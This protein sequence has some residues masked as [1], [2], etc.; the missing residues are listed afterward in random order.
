VPDTPSPSL[1]LTLDVLR[2]AAE[3]TRLRIL[4]LLTEGELSVSDLTDILGQS[5]PRIS[6]HLKLLVEAGLVERHREGAWA[7]FRLTD[8]GVALSIIRPTIESLDRSDPQLLEDRTRLDAVRAQRSQTAQAFF[9]RL[10]PE[11]DRIRSLHA[12]EVVVEAAVLD[13]LGPARIRN[14]VDLGTGTGRMVQ[15]LAPRAGRTVGLD[16][17]HAMLSVARANLEKAG[18]RGIELR[19]GDIYAPPFPRDT[20]DLVVIHQVLHYLD[21]PARAIR[22]AAR[23][24]APGGR[25]LVVD[26][27]PHNLEFLREA[28]AHR[29]L[30]FAPAQVAGWLDEAGLDCTLS[31]EIAPPRKGDEQLTV[32]LWLGQ[33]RRVVTDWPMNEP[34]REV[35]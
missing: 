31:R 35:A 14:L 26:F 9:S 3:E 7:F 19:Q 10:A 30:G 2:A 11:W 8:R 21:D 28:Q 4:A 1:D 33:D 32:S 17:S 15:L 6:R 24:V 23:L 12:P 34:D 13:A 5:Q 16:A 27:A 25:I 29:R 18:L 20:F 22:E